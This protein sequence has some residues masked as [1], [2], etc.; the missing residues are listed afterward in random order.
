MES[1]K[2]IQDFVNNLIRQGES[3]TLDFKLKI[4]S[5]EKIA[6]TISA[7]AN[8]KGGVLVIG[9][10]DQKK[11]IGIDPEEERYMI[12]SANEECCIPSAI[13]HVEELK[14]F[15][16]N[17]PEQSNDDEISLLLVRIHPTT[18]GL[19]SVKSSA[20]NLKTYRRVGD[21]TLAI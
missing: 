3:D 11:I 17:Y 15:N 6:R 20:G 16:E 10:S 4:T 9:V 12:E 13:I 14:L 18:Q 2:N 19:I 8:S 21:Q 7:M 5:K 1:E